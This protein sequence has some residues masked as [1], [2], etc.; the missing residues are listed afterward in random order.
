[1]TKTKNKTSYKDTFLTKNGLTGSVIPITQETFMTRFIKRY[2]HSYSLLGLSGF[3][4]FYLNQ[5]PLAV[6]CGAA[7]IASAIVTFLQQRRAEKTIYPENMFIGPAFIVSETGEVLRANQKGGELLALYGHNLQDLLETDS[8]DEGAC[9]RLLNSDKKHILQNDDVIYVARYLNSTQQFLVTRFNKSTNKNVF[10]TDQQNSLRWSQHVK[11]FEKHGG[12]IGDQNHDNSQL[13]SLQESLKSWIKN[14]NELKTFLTECGTQASKNMATSEKIHFEEVTFIDKEDGKDLTFR[15]MVRED[16]DRVAG[17]IFPVA[18]DTS[19]KT[20]NNQHNA[21]SP[22]SAPDHAQPLK[23]DDNLYAHIFADSPAAIITTS[24]DGQ[25]EN[26]NKSFF[27]LTLSADPYAENI[28][29]YFAPKD[30]DK[31]KEIIATGTPQELNFTKDKINKIVKLSA[32]KF[33]NKDHKDNIIFYIVDLSEGKTLEDKFN[34]VQ[35][36]QAVG[37]LAGGVA[38]DFNNLLTAIL[39]HTE[40]LL[41]RTAPADSAFSDLMQIQQNANRAGKLVKQLLAFSRQQTLQPKI[42]NLTDI[43]PDINELLRR[44][45]GENIALKSEYGSDLSS[46]KA[47]ITQLEQVILNLAVNA[48]DAMDGNGTLTIKTENISRKTSLK[49]GYNIMPEGDYVGIYVSDTGCGMTT[50]TQKKIFEPFFTTKDIGK[51]TGLGL[52]TVYGIVKQS[53]GFI[54]VESEMGKGTTFKLYFPAYHDDT[55]DSEQNN[56][57]DNSAPEPQQDAATKEPHAPHTKTILIAED[58]NSVREFV[59]RALTMRGYN[60]LEAD[61]GEDALELFKEHQDKI[62]LILSDVM[63]PGM[64]GP[65]WVREA[66][67]CADHIKVI[68]MSGYAEDTFRDDPAMQSDGVSAKFL[69]KPFSLKVLTKT[70][71]DNL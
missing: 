11:F 68:F 33:T 62:D 38:H 61:C 66:K 46:I 53:Q 1:M 47:D 19:Q 29:D 13:T 12:T 40:L 36:M 25:I 45:V 30:H 18:S 49:A 34:Q 16:E 28:Y 59:V 3:S 41:G 39:G 24:Q 37:Q 58:E 71:K 6:A 55:Q 10:G 35:K 21:P 23:G 32:K 20:D 60:I 43:L 56:I 14:D 50:E 67:K 48:K 65:S 4:A 54:F 69:S 63:M 57:A 17:F 42:I 26:Y 31:I 27:K 44:L 7:A 51:G 9:F 22:A 2:W 5:P 8:F 70:I 15:V 64:D 52:S